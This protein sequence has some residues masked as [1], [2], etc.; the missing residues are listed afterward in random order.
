MLSVCRFAVPLPAHLSPKRLH[1][2]RFLP[3]RPDVQSTTWAF[4][5][6]EFIRRHT[7]NAN[8]IHG[9]PGTSLQGKWGT[10]IDKGEIFDSLPC[11]TCGCVMLRVS[12]CR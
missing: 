2:R 7:Y 10:E 6:A 8:A 12:L 1:A 4:N 5:H 11:V 3:L 9:Y